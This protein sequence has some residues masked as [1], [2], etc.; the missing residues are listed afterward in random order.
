ME[1]QLTSWGEEPADVFFLE[2]VFQ[3]LFFPRSTAGTVAVM[4]AV[5]RSQQLQLS[6]L[7]LHSESSSLGLSG[8]R[9]RKSL[10]FS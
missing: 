4:A 2:L 3:S 7:T 1:G 9:L 5:A 8:V 10:S 6:L